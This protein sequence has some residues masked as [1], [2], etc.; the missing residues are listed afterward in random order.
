MAE[1]PHFALPFRFTNGGAVV[2]EQDTADE[3]MTCAL[4]VL[5]C[6]KGY[7][8]EVPEFGYPDPTFTEGRPD[9]QVVEAVLGNWEPRA[10]ELVETRADALDA[11]VAY[12]Y[13]RIGAPSED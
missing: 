3:I 2:V 13:V 10:Q 6:P 9:A 4:A 8:V 5:L 7:R 1:I 11:L 12:V